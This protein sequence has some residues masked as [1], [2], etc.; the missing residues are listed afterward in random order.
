[1]R[2]NTGYTFESVLSLC[3]FITDR[4]LPRQI[5]SKRSAGLY[6]ISPI[7]SLMLAIGDFN[8]QSCGIWNAFW[9]GLI[10]LIKSYFFFFFICYPNPVMS[11][12]SALFS[13]DSENPRS[14]S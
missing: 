14:A 2:I 11:V 12:K 3:I 13:A 4:K 5:A 6:D 9:S 10:Y 7:S 1:M 8:P